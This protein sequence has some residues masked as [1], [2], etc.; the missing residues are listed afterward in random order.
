M[1]AH[2]VSLVISV[3]KDKEDNM[4]KIAGNYYGTTIFDCCTY[5]IGFGT[6]Q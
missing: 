6:T 2:I 5:Y 4:K 3:C 1:Q